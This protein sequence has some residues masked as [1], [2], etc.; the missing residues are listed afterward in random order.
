MPN[1]AYT[2][3]IYWSCISM[4]VKRSL[5][6]VGDSKKVLIS[7]P[8][9]V[10]DEMGYA[11]H[12][13]QSGATHPNA[14]AF[15]IKNESGVFEIVSNFDTNTFRADY[16]V[17]IGD[18]VYVLDA[19]QKKSKKGIKTPQQDVERIKQRLV[20]AKKHSKEG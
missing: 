4:D 11:L 10:K 14:K 20:A 1:I 8:D 9:E 7:F 18:S 3:Y 6:W 15:K 19:F 17:K 2:N 16:A 13:A 12:L 5:I